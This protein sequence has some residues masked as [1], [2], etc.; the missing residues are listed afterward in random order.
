M[1]IKVFGPGCA[2][3]AEAEKLVREVVAAKGVTAE[4][5]KVTDIKEIMKAG[6]LSTPAVSVNGKVMLTG[7]VPNKDE[8]AGWLELA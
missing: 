5:T 7:R 1:E 2:K 4:V 6:V 3:C 8:V